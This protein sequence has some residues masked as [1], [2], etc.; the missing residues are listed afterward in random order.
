MNPWKRKMLGRE[1]VEEFLDCEFETIEFVV[2]LGHYFGQLPISVAN[3][4]TGVD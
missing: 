2:Y 1:V 4:L 3:V